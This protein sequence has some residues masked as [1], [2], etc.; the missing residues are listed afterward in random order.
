MRWWEFALLG[1]GGGA[2]FEVLAIFN[3]LAGWQAA[4]R[5]GTGRVKG[6][7]P[8]ARTFI[9]VPVHS[10]MLPIRMGLGATAAAIFGVTGQIN[11][12]FVAIAL[13]FAAPSVLAQLG[14]VPQVATAIT[15]VAPE[16]Q[17]PIGNGAAAR[18]GSTDAPGVPAEV[19]RDS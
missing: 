3:C 6:R 15:G 5:T 8:K 18:A 12:V 7:P 9:D 10:C 11:G 14:A 1:G 4:R 16:P 2:L 19:P 13:G 17:S